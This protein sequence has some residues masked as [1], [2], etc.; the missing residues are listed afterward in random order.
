MPESY[1]PMIAAR[2]GAKGAPGRR[3]L[4]RLDSF[5]ADLSGLLTQLQ[6]DQ[7]V[8]R[9]RLHLGPV[10]ALLP[11]RPRTTARDGMGEKS[12]D[13]EACTRCGT[14]ARGCPY[15]AIR[16][17][18]APCFDMDRCHGCWRCYNRCPMHAISTQKFRDGPYYAAPGERL[19]AKLGA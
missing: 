15:E 11:R 3:Q 19:T 1:P 13:D 10:N 5:V 6:D 4:A 14:C 17:A 18:P 2:M 12:V 8:E 9:R 16:L 7:P